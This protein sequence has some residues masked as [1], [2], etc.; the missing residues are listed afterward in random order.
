[1]I[2]LGIRI[3]ATTDVD[4]LAFAGLN[5]QGIRQLRAPDEPLPGPLLAA[6]ET[7]AGDLGLDPHWLNTGPASQWQ[8]GLPPGLDDRVTWRTYGGLGVGIVSRIDL[9]YFKLYAA[10][11]DIGTGSVHYQDLVAL[12]PSDADLSAAA[13][14]IQRQDPGPDFHRT[15]SE[16]IRHVRTDRGRIR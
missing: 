7:V 8:T 16:V 3:R 14:W 5:A 1:M 12:H 10:A 15:V 9:V 13:E 6:A 2:L 4:I 11:D